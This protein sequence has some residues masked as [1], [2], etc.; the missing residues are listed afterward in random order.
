[1]IDLH[2]RAVFLSFVIVLCF[3]LELCHCERNGIPSKFISIARHKRSEPTIFTV[4]EDDG[5]EG[6]E[7]DHSEHV[8]RRRDAGDTTHKPEISLFLLND[9]HHQVMIDWAGEG[10]KV[11]VCV[12]R[13]GTQTNASASHVF[14]SDDYGTTFKNETNKFRT[15]GGR[16]AIIRKFYKND[17]F[18]SRFVF[19]DVI[20]KYIF[21]TQD[22]GKT[23]SNVKVPFTPSEVTHHPFN[24]EVLLIYDMEDPERK[25]WISENF[26]ESWRIIGMFVKSYYWSETTFPPTLYV[27]R[28]EP[29]GSASVV[30]STE[31]FRDGTRPTTV[32]T[33][34][35]D[36]EVKDE[37]LFAVKKVHLLGSSSKDATLQ[38]WISYQ[39]GPFLRA[40]FPNT[41]EHQHYYVANISEGQVM[42]CV[43]HDQFMS[44]LYVSSVPRSAHHEVRFSLSLERILYFN[45]STN[46]VDT[47]LS[48][49]SD[50]TF[51]D[52]HPVEGVRGIFIASQLTSNF[53]QI[54]SK[55]GPE[56][57]T[58][59]ITFDQGAQWKP[60]QP[61]RKDVYGNF[62]DCER[63]KG[64]SLHV[65][66]ELSHLY[67]A[68]H[69]LPVFSKKSAPGLILATGTIGTS[70]KGHTALY[71][72]TDAGINW[73]QVL[74]GN[75]L[76]TIGDHGGII[77]AVKFYRGHGET[78][79]LQYS[80]D[81]GETWQTSSFFSESLRIYGLMTEPGENTTVFT[82]F[83]SKK[84]K[85]QWIIVKVDMKSLFQYPCSK[86][87]YKTWS[88]SDGR[89]GRM[90]LLGRKQVFE[91]RVPHSNCLNQVNYDRPISVENC[92]CDREDFECDFGFI[93][94]MESQKCYQDPEVSI[95]LYA[96]PNTC[97]PGHFYNRTNGYRQI[98]GDTCVG[99]RA[100]QYT[101]S[102]TACP[103]TEEQEFLL[104]SARQEI[105]RYDLLNPEAGLQPLPL[106]DLK[107]VIALDFDMSANCIYWS[108]VNE[109]K[110]YRLCFDG[111]HDVETLVDT[112]VHSVEGLAF[113]WISKNLYFVDG[114]LKT[115]QVIRTDISNYGRMRRTLLD[116]KEL[117][118]PRGIA[119]HPVRGYLYITDWSDTS[120]KVARAF[121]DGTNLI[122]LF[123]IGTVGWPN[124]IT[125]DFQSE[126]IFFADAKLDYIASADLDGRYMRKIISN[127]DKVMQP[128]A[129]GI[130]KSTLFWDDWNVDQVLQAD[131]ESGWGI[132][133]IA[134]FTRTG[135]VDLKVFGHWSQ[136]GNNSCG[137]QTTGCSHLCV[138]RPNNQFA[139]L[140]PDGM[141]RQVASSGYN[142]Q[143]MCPDGSPIQENG[144]CKSAGSTCPPN[145]FKCKNERCIPSQW[146]C[147]KD[148]DCGDNSDEVGPECGEKSCA[149]PSWQCNNGRCI[150]QSWVCD[151]DDDCGDNSDEEHCHHEECP[152]KSFKCRNGR[153]I[154]INWV[155][156]MEDDCRDGSDEDNCTSTVSSQCRATELTCV[157]DGR[158]LPNSWQ[159]D[160]DPDCADNSDELNCESHMCESWQFQCPNKQCIFGSW[161]CDGEFDCLDGSD[162]ANCTNA[163]TPSPLP[164]V[165]LRPFLPPTSGNCTALMF[166]C[167]NTE[168]IPF[169]WRCDGLKDCGDGSDEEGCSQ[170]EIHTNPT[171]PTSTTHNMPVCLEDQFQC[172]SGKCIW[173]AWRCDGT[174]ECL[175][176][177][178]DEENCHPPSSC[179]E[180]DTFRCR[181]SSGCISRTQYCDGHKDCADG[182]DE[183][184]CNTAPPAVDHCPDNFFMCD[185]GFCQE[186][187]KYCDR[188]QDCVDGTDE[189]HNCSSD[190]GK[191][192]V[193]DFRMT[194][195][196]NTSVSVKW[197]VNGQVE[198]SSNLVYMPSYIVKAT[199]GNSPAWKNM[200]WTSN[201]SCEITNLE[202]YTF[203][204][205]K[206][207]IREQNGTNILPP[208]NSTVFQTQQGI[209]SPP[210]DVKVEQDG[211]SFIVRWSPPHKPNGVIK[212]YRVYLS[213]PIPV[214]SHI[215]DGVYFVKLSPH[216]TNKTDSIWVTVSNDLY[217]SEESEHVEIVPSSVDTPVHILTNESTETSFKLSWEPIPEVDGYTISHSRKE[218]KYLIGKITNKTTDTHIE[219]SDLA[220]G[221]QYTFEI[222]AYKDQK[223][224]PPQTI[225]VKTE[226]QPLLP[227]ESL[228]AVPMKD[229]GTTVKLSWNEPPY[230]G[231]KVVWSYRIVWGKSH[232][233]LELGTD[234]AHTSN[235]TLV[236]EG[237][238]ACETY[239]IAVMVGGPI[240]IGPIKLK[241][242]LTGEDPLAPP[243]NLHV[244]LVNKT[245]LITWE[246]SCPLAENSNSTHYY[247]LTITEVIRNE[248]S[249]YKLMSRNNHTQSHQ[250]DAHWGGLYSIYVSTSLEGARQSKPFECQGPVIPTPY[251]LT[252][253]PSDG[254]FFW[255]NNRY[256]PHDLLNQKYSYILYISKNKNM[257]DATT[258]ECDTP[259][260]VVN[261]LSIG[262]I[263]YATVAFKDADGYLSPQSQSMRFEKHIGDEI[264]LS[265]S[266]VMGVAVSVFL[267]VVALIVV[268][269][270][271]A[272]RHRRLA[273]SFLTFA[274]THYDRS[275]GTTLI[276]TDHNLDEDDDSPMIRGFSDDEPL[277]IA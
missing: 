231:K 74:M 133:P 104:V 86:D 61:P 71:V 108:D 260:I 106:L 64:C 82:I 248:T 247:M 234:V 150:V 69:T 143:C 51:A 223:I 220:P 267:V 222:R 186:M 261:D 63:A 236:V 32:I 34:V 70:L 57:L 126:R 84:D 18:T 241:Q 239:F 146:Q 66:Q 118:N 218:E 53:S 78:N 147:D 157:S 168:C 89:S 73:Y 105:L 9:S 199:I 135:L 88:P 138:G 137:N 217:M 274:N 136:L 263:Y 92:P 277:V 191:Y 130:Y 45:P 273:R 148:D 132:A 245:M 68:F 54:F 1:M 12:T 111:K 196:T 188:N 275:Q 216:W 65:S 164:T 7:A 101:P 228:Q 110:I 23:V 40:E 90:C 113:D 114:Q 258:Y 227:V 207:Y 155:C 2:L 128:F 76:Y 42:V 43:A 38:M 156:D 28:E 122:T 161:V 276:T 212:E 100:Y 265:Q 205:L 134:N 72:S 240:G 153:C 39:G 169:W 154:H 204:V 172:K 62:I 77:V 166:R 250:V 190:S 27:E 175:P 221:M 35:E 93:D 142:E 102:I 200:S 17:R 211:D 268:V 50:T 16:P 140:C 176:D 151:Y 170:P 149:S 225:N 83:G 124:G 171:T 14:I 30:S 252:F 226:G 208:M 94:D 194:E 174:K 79:E 33:G 58:S 232:N 159:C 109:K 209:P 256:F 19:I 192:F 112:K 160:G 75:Y 25:L 48:E 235:T 198:A 253:N 4:G 81:E 229:I 266:S 96:V 47:W 11:V 152:D 173:R 121:L 87:D 238:E 29:S 206:V 201:M 178:E 119:V 56:H 183:D 210:E 99:G 36:F 21:V 67:P 203:Y 20:N 197:K 117:D 131:K 15:F 37:F 255:R 254:S 242:V 120:P 145:F 185:G 13:D 184:A 257:S 158:C 60:L 31:L 139:C 262:V 44:N 163:T 125:I 233:D 219:I 249:S 103:V 167:K 144:T 24:A 162:E 98:P 55:L 129:L 3:T 97:K 195:I 269:G 91:R 259:P 107:M 214:R 243:R 230:K 193:T 8:R 6:P 95:D 189:H 187:F 224:G 177:G 246:P 46:W 127:S 85:H 116:S 80:T 244:S 41:L 264:V 180:T 165:P 179:N 271:L 182:S 5:V 141:E 237:L 10:S 49:V 52:L 270:I 272:V 215:P 202:P 26:G 115:L 22:Y 213:S 123:G 181:Q 251:E 59:Y